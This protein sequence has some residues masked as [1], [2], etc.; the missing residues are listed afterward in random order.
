MKKLI[1]L[2]ILTALVGC[3]ENVL[4]FECS[5]SLQKYDWEYD[6]D[7]G[8]D[9]KSQGYYR[10]TKILV[11]DKTNKTMKYAKGKATPYEVNGNLLVSYS[12]FALRKFDTTTNK[13]GGRNCRKIENY[14]N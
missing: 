4:T 8:M 5:I 1:L 14:F 12:G 7:S 10:D 9:Y 2:I 3:A 11:I 6:W 13:L